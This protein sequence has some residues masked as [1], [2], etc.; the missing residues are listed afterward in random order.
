[1]HRVCDVGFTTLVCCVCRTLLI[2]ADGTVDLH[3][4]RRKKRL[5]RE[6]EQMLTAVSEA[7][8]TLNAVDVKYAMQDRA[9]RSVVCAELSAVWGVEKRCQVAC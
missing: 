5:D 7:R 8:A 9:C 2:Q 3:H 1:M 6:L 4:A